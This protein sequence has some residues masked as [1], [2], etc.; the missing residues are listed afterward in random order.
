MPTRKASIAFGAWMCLLGGVFLAVPDAHVPVR[1]AAGVSAAAVI[2]AGVRHHKPHDRIGWHLLM[3][4]VVLSA[5]GTAAFGAPDWATDQVPE[6]GV[7]GPV[8]IIAAYGLLAGVLLIFIR[9]RTGGAR[10]RAALLDALTVTSGVALL[11]WTFV[12]GPR[13]HDGGT[14]DGSTLAAIAFPLG[15]LLCLGMLTRLL[16]AAGPKPVSAGLLGGGLVV[17]LLA[18]VSS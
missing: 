18:D 8:L 1:V 16:T 3:V 5:L 6:L 15:D 11:A 17:M 10:D 12:L 2:A 4:A 14:L 9:R 13:L 7:F